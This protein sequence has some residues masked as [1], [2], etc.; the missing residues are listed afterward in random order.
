M[1]QTPAPEQNQLLAALSADTQKRLFPH[2]E[3]VQLPLG[4]SLYEPGCRVRNAYFPIDAI[5]SLVYVTQNGATTEI[6]LVGNEGI[7]GAPLFLGGDSTPSQAVVQNAGFA[8][9]L[10][11]S[12]LKTEFNRYTE[13]FRLLLLYMQALITQTSQTAVCNRHHSI[14]QRLCRWLLL[15][16][17][18]LQI[19]EFNM[20]QEL[21]ASM[22]GAR[23]ESITE[24][25]SKL[26]KLR[27]IDYSCGHIKV[28]NRYKLEELCCECYAV[29]KKETD[30]LLPKPSAEFAEPIRY[31]HSLLVL[32]SNGRKVMSH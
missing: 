9:R 19:D 2:L 7:I 27:I 29:V 17:D 4:R 32:K 12:R 31:S 30:R 10:H 1:L 5:I 24:A 15:S 26:Q 21:M 3:L 22:L 6:S 25:A 20:T 28:L 23:R 18:R 14:D 13:L 16:L 11:G 8:Y